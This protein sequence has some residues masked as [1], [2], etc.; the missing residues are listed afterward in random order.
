M[1]HLPNIIPMVKHG[2]GNIIIPWE[3]F[4]VAVT[5]R[6]VRADGKLN[7][8]STDILDGNLVQN[9]QDLRLG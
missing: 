1:H 4:S 9:A 8:Q 7:E 2:V 3:C 6:L 5:C